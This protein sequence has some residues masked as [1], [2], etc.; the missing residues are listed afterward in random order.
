MVSCDQLPN[1]LQITNLNC[2][3]TNHL[4]VLSEIKNTYE[5]IFAWDIYEK[6]EKLRNSPTEILSKVTEKEGLIFENNNKFNFDSMYL[7]LIRCYETFLNGDF[8]QALSQIND[9]VQILK[10]TKM[11]TFFQ[12]ILN[13][14]FHVIYATKAYIM[15]FLNENTQQILKD[16]K[17][18]L[19]FNSVEKAAVYAIKSKV[20]LEYPYKGNKIA[21]RL[22]EFARDFNSTE[23]H[24][25]IIWLIAKGRQRRFDRDR[26]L[27]FR[28]ELEAA[29][30]LCSFEDNPEFLLS[31]SNV[32][33]EA[34]LDYNM[35]KQYFT[36]GFLG[37]SFSSSLQ[38]LK[39]ECLLDSDNNF[40]IVLYLDFLYEL[41][42]CPMRR[43]I[44]VNQIL[45]YYTYIEANPKALINYLDIYL[46]QDI[47]YVQKKQQII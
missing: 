15:A 21:L 31:A 14:C 35:A 12:P 8:S 9:L 24:W 38:L 37:G 19:S 10:C 47:D 6:V 18:C 3:S 43:L 33:L 27:P 41:Y 34:G 40:S 39:V 22:A 20:F 36:R 26:T 2:Q 17:P 32:F 4:D 13:A 28:D 5:S 45:L 11:D 7:C 44:I 29:K 1:S 46:N 42:T 25:I 30:K 23:N 16:I